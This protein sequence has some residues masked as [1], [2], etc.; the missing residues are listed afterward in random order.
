VIPYLQGAYGNTSFEQMYPEVTDKWFASN[1]Y[2]L[3]KKEQEISYFQELYQKYMGTPFVLELN[4]NIE[5]FDYINGGDCE[6]CAIGRTSKMVRDSILLT[7]IDKALN[8][9]DRVIVTFGHG[10]AL[11]VEPALKQIINKERR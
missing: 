11:A 1:G 5:K 6:F 7:K 8:K 3:S 9:Y 4:D 2:P 10:H